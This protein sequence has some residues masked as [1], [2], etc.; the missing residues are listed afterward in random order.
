MND[1]TD[2]RR[3]GIYYCEP[4]DFEGDWLQTPDNKEAVEVIV[5]LTRSEF[6]SI[7]HHL[8]HVLRSPR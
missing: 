6:Q 8:L 4:M 3:L 1:D 7:R 5:C 2:L